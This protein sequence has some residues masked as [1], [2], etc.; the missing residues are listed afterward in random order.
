[1]RIFTFLL[2]VFFL[3]QA[4]GQTSLNFWKTTDL[5]QLNS[6][7]IKTRAYTPSEFN[8][9]QLDFQGVK[10]ILALAPMEFTA[11]AKSHPL[12][13][14]LPIGDGRVETFQVWESPIM[15]QELKNRW[16][17]IRTF[18]GQGLREKGLTIRFDFTLN[19]FHA[20][21]LEAGGAVFYIEPLTFGQ[22]ELYM[23]Y[24]RANYPSR[25][26]DIT[27]LP[28]VDLSTKKQEILPIKNLGQH[29]GTDGIQS[30][31]FN[32]TVT[33]R[34]YRL[35]ITSTTE[36]AEAFGGT[37]AAALSEVV[38]AV[39]TLTAV[40]ERDLDIRFILPAKEDTL[41]FST[42]NPD[43]FPSNDL[44]F[45]LGANNTV[46][47]PR[48]GKSAYDV[49]HVF[50]KYTGGGALGVGAL[51]VICDNNNKANGSSSD[52]Y[53]AGNNFLSTAGQEIGHQFVGNHTFNSCSNENG[54]T[55]YEP[56]CG[57]T[58]M[59]YVT[60]GPDLY[61]HNISI[62][63]IGNFS[64]FQDANSCPTKTKTNNRVPQ[65]TLP[66]TDGFYIPFGTPFDLTAT[67]TD[68]DGDTGL[69]YCWE[70]HDLGP[71]VPDLAQATGNCPIFRTYTP[72]TSPT[73]VF[74]KMSKILANSTNPTDGEVLPAYGRNLTFTCTVRDNVPNG[75]GVAY[76]TMKFKVADASGPF[77]VTAPNSAITKWTVDDF[78]EIKWEVAASNLAPVNCKSVNIELSTDGGLTYPIVLAQNSPNDGSH[79]IK[80]P[81]N[82]T[83]KARVRIHAADNIFFDI[84]NSNFKIENAATPGWG[85]SVGPNSGQIC[86]PSTFSTTIESAGWLGFSSNIQLE[87]IAGLP[88][89]AVATFGSNSISPGANAA[90]GIDF[91]NVTAE[92]NWEVIL[93]GFTT[94]GDSIKRSLYFTTV[95]NNFSNLA[96]VTIPDGTLGANIL[97]KL[98]WSSSVDANT[99]DFQLSTD[100]AF[101]AGSIISNLTNLTVLETSPSATLEYKTMYFWHVRPVNECGLGAWTEPFVFGTEVLNCQK[102]E[103]I[104]LPKSISF[105]GTPT[106]ESTISV[107]FN[108]VITDVNVTKCMGFHEFMKDLSFSLV[109]PSGK[110]VWLIRQKCGNYNGNFSFG[111][112]DEAAMSFSC[113]PSDGG[114]HRPS[115][116][117]L[118]NFDG[119][120][121][122]GAWKLVVKDTTSG[123]GGTIN[124]FELEF[125]GSVALESP[126][127]INNVI[128]TIDGGTN[129]EINPP[130]LKVGDNNNADA[131]L[132]YTLVVLPKYG[133]LAFNWGNPLEIG[134][135]FTQEDINNGL[136]RY[137]DYGSALNDKFTFVVAD[138]E[139]GFIPKT[140]FLITKT[141]VSTENLTQN[142]VS[143]F[144]LVPNPTTDQTTIAFDFPLESEAQMTVVNTAGQLI[145]SQKIGSG[146]NHF[147]LSTATLPSG[148]YLVTVKTAEG[149]RTKRL[150]VHH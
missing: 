7:S 94:A 35:A 126:F 85:L 121:T 18:A 71:K 148:L 140:Q 97:P 59:S 36:Y 131:Q 93:R 44:G 46:V 115:S 9:Y 89:G 111:L 101:S 16:P 132:K 124:A 66:Y 81:N 67:A 25:S 68:P 39:N 98:T 74:P 53:P 130:L 116:S 41:V 128:L 22:T 33:L 40:W 92:G 64:Q 54:A 79:F 145:V 95:S 42:A 129:A 8:A 56:Y 3:N 138:G 106:I 1:M 51:G 142:V 90:L 139:G 31:W 125:C 4:A 107:P 112:D 133:H 135:K 11:A 49:G 32:D 26:A 5:T 75:G 141:N 61:Y 21:V 123:S 72:T 57:S 88:P 52:G 134:A 137:F 43:P 77:R 50:T 100:P 23:A 37:Q 20:I 29:F 82:L 104:D 99:Y 147:G 55:A 73:R 19:G 87:V 17:G 76:E 10:S 144:S 102:A 120:P 119:E 110:K 108:A 114:D 150:A 60:W 47:N 127:L 63:E 27:A 105:S 14:D 117:P 109:S 30:R 70:Q 34:T 45:L 80:V 83:T 118:S 136:L 2:V 58:I 84:S 6:E 62:E 12:L 65:V 78:V 24:N 103:A 91:N 146:A 86:L 28:T 15:E 113:P 38:T 143:E 149:L 48:I 96:L 69:S 122:N 13:L